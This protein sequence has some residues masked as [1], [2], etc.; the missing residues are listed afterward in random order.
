MNSSEH[1]A[2][3]AG[4]LWVLS[5]VAGGFG[6]FYLRSKVI[7]PG[8]AT[9]TA[10]NLMAHEFLFRA[11][12]VG[13]LLGQVFLV[14]LALTFFHL[15]KEVNKRLASVLLAS[16]IISVGLA[17]INTLNHFGALMLL[18]QADFLTTFT[19]DQ[20]NTTAFLLLRLANGPGQGLIEIFWV[21]Y[22]LSLGMLMIRS[23]FFPRV[24]GILLMMM[25]VGFAINILDKFLIPQFH[26]LMFT[27]LAMGLGALGGIPTM[28]WLLIKG[29]KVESLNQ[30][31]S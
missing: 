10:A 2:R 3:L 31:T 15:F 18:S 20:R 23:G 11:A 17:V 5:G 30:R 9:A 1:T 27:R 6:L 16:A 22:Y 4:L 26:P 8:N 29:A 24:L 19:P 28:L 21:P 25:G 7:V 12:I 13:T 14:F